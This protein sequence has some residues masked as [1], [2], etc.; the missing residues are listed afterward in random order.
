MNYE[1]KILSN[2]KLITN[3][4]LKI[5]YKNKYIIIYKIYNNKSG[6]KL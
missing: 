4:D 3:I 2:V 6:N 1:K 5:R